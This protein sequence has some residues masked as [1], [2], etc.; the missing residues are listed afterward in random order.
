MSTVLKTIQ[1]KNSV[2]KEDLNKILRL[3][4]DDQ[5]K[6]IEK[7]SKTRQKK[8]LEYLENIPYL[9]ENF[10]FPLSRRESFN[11]VAAAAASVSRGG[12]S[13]SGKKEK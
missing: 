10:D 5:L 1:K 2:N 13:D 6:I 4:G 9:E 8:L 12:G 11:V 3:S 7:I